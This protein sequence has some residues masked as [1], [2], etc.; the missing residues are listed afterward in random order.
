MKI[1]AS[2]IK[3]NC[4]LCGKSI[5]K[6][7][8]QKHLQFCVKE[9]PLKET[10]NY[11][12][13]IFDGMYHCPCCELK[14]DSQRQIIS[15]YWRLHTESGQK[16]K[17]QPASLANGLHNSWNRGLT[18]KTDSRVAKNAAAVSKAT[19]GRPGRPQSERNKIQT[20]LR[21]SLHNPGGKSKWYTV[22]GQK[23]QGTWERNIAIKLEE[24][25]I[26]WYKP[27]VNKDVWR[28]ELNGKTRSYTPD[29][30][31][32]DL[33]IYLEVKGYWWGNDRAKMAAVLEQHTDK[34]LLVIEKDQYEKIIGGELVW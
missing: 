25:G 13:W 5:S 33:N 9:K 28:Y 12:D 4:E 19:T 2:K 31:L 6:P 8:Y 20:S 22:A 32:V 26:K 29:I 23:V 27:K 1:L 18:K 21:M 14:T 7:N 17:P 10:I 34:R 15:H 30:Y 11:K 3:L 16:H 24:L